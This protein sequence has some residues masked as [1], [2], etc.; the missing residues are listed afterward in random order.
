MLPSGAEAVGEGLG[1]KSLSERRTHSDCLSTV[2]GRGDGEE[3]PLAGHSL[4][5]VDAAILEFQ[6]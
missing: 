4:E 1:R 5:F 6:P 3:V 2:L